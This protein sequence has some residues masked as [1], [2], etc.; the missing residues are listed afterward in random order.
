MR[1]SKRFFIG[2]DEAGNPKGPGYF[3]ISWVATQ[4]PRAIADRFKMLRQKRRLPED[5]VF[6][7][8]ETSKAVKRAFY[9]VLE[10]L[11][12][13]AWALVVDKGKLGPDHDA[14]ESLE[15]W[16]EFVVKLALR[17]PLPVIAEA[18]ITLHDYDNPRRA[19]QLVRRL[20]SSG[21]ADPEKRPNK[22]RCR[23][24]RSQALVQCADMVAG[25]VL[26][27]YRY[28]ETEFFDLAKP[29]LEDLWEV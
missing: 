14:R 5:F 27:R 4:E 26:R 16:A 23:P 2:G 11:P 6:S 20:L 28:G 22:V 15:I 18:V 13:Q 29:K 8:H 7:F 12:V 10:S 21:L 25:A 19:E 3:V 9:P 1:K 17:L 24:K